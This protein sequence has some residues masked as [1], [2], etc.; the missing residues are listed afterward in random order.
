MGRASASASVKTVGGIAAAH[1]GV[2]S[3][4]ELANSLAL[5]LAR[6]GWGSSLAGFGA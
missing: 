3:V 4:L 2:G 6:E 1:S 5:A